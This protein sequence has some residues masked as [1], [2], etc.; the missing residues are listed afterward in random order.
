LHTNNLARVCRPAHRADY[1]RLHGEAVTHWH[2]HAIVNVDA[3]L[4]YGWTDLLASHGYEVEDV[5]PV[6]TRRYR[7]VAN[8]DNR[9]DNE[10]VILAHK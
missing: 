6:K 4:M 5:W 8:D 7:G 1:Y 2:T 3:P 10:V 9:A